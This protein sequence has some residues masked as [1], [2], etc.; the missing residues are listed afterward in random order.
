ML[1][2]KTIR[3]TCEDYM[4]AYKKM[5]GLV[6]IAISATNGVLGQVNA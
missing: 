4:T 3:F 2:A 5:W 1:D 6:I